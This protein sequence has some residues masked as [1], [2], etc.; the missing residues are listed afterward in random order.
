MAAATAKAKIPGRSCGSPRHD[1]R[2]RHHVFGH[3]GSTTEAPRWRSARYAALSRQRMRHFG[4]RHEV[5]RLE[6]QRCAFCASLSWFPSCPPVC[7]VDT[8]FIR[9]AASLKMACPAAYNRPLIKS[10]YSIIESFRF[11]QDRIQPGPHH[12]R[13]GPFGFAAQTGRGCLNDVPDVP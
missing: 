11:R 1:C 10:G 4:G 3:P 5:P 6:T 2:H 9:F 8:M 13:A 12:A 7:I